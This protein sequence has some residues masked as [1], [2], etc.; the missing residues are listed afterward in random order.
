MTEMKLG[1]TNNGGNPPCYMD[2][3]IRTRTARLLASLGFEALATTSLGL[4]NML[5]HVGGSGELFHT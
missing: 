5:G 1:G 4:A 2:R 3:A